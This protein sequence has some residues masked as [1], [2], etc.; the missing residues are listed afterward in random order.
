MYFPQESVCFSHLGAEKEDDANRRYAGRATSADQS[1]ASVS[2]EFARPNGV[3]RQFTLK[4]FNYASSPS[5]LQGD[6]MRNLLADAV[7]QS[8]ADG[9]TTRVNVEG[10]EPTFVINERSRRLAQE[11]AMGWRD[12]SH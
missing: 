6:R 12:A 4:S 7:N 5:G 2:G 3:G 10:A 11:L 9:A 1:D 8:V